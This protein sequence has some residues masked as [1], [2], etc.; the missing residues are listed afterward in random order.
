MNSAKTKN[1]WGCQIEGLKIRRLAPSGEK[2][3]ELAINEPLI[4]RTGKGYPN[5]LPIMGRSGAGKSTLMNVLSSTSRAEPDDS[6]VS[7]IFPDGRTFAW[8]GG[9]NVDRQLSLIRK[10]YF[11]YAFQNANLLAHLTVEENL[12]FGRLHRGEEYRAARERAIELMLSAF[13]HDA[14]EV[15]RLMLL[16]PT[17]LSGGERQRVALLAAVARDPYVLFADE[18]TGS[19]DRFTRTKVMGLLTDW[20]NEKPDQRLLIWVTHHD[21]DPF[22]NDAECRLW[23]EDGTARFERRIGE[24]QWQPDALT[25]EKSA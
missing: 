2:D 17:Q 3:F 7:W 10:N 9:S 15:S 6:C 8:Q 12:V 1:C 20:L 4:I 18:P 23:V 13:E 21:R 11:G 16:F 19:L 24:D 14:R 25:L 22:D 5:R